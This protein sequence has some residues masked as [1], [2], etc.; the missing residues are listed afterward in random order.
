VEYK[1]DDGG[2][3]DYFETKYKKDRTNDCVIRAI[4]IATGRDYLTIWK[5]LFSLSTKM[6]FM[7]NDQKCYE[8]YLELLG[9]VKNKP[10]RK[11]NG[12]KYQV[13]KL[14]INKNKSYIFQTT[15]HLT[16]IIDGEHRDIWDCGN[17]CANSYYTKG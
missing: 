7:P 12:K 5:E 1:Y 6:G 4:A 9:W 17:W 2:R 13:K 15:R 14:P 10:L 8:E 3:D 16:A 11:I